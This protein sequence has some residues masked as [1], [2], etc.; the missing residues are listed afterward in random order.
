MKQSNIIRNRK[1]HFIK[2]LEHDYDSLNDLLYVYKK[3]AGVYSNV[4]IGDFHLEFNK[5]SELV[6]IEI[7][8]ASGILKEYKIS[9]KVLE[10]INKAD[11]KVVISGNS[12]LIFLIICS[13]GQTKSATIA[14]NNLESPVMDAITLA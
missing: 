3:G 9:R 10:N 11:L 5:N 6:G 13:E 12:L 4:V 14:M 1:E 7:L 2:N 8:N